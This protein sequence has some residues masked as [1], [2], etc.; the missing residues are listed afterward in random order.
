ASA[1]HYR[2]VPR[3]RRVSQDH[4][5]SQIPDHAALAS[6]NLTAPEEPAAEAAPPVLTEYATITVSGSPPAATATELRAADA[7]MSIITPAPRTKSDDDA[8]A[9]AES[10]GCT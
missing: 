6:C 2:L 7:P 10:T 9:G 1:R 3:Y 4:V 8:P 5:A